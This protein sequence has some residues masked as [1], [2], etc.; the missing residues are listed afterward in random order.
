MASVKELRGLIDGLKQE[1]KEH[2]NI[3]KSA[4]E[5]T[6]SQ[7]NQLAQSASN[8]T[9]SLPTG[10]SSPSSSNSPFHLPQI[11]LPTFH[12]KPKE[13]LEHFLEKLTNL[14]QSSGVPS[15]ISLLIS[16]SN[17]YMI[18]VLMILSVKLKKSTLL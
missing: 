5:T 15:H 3:T 8:L 14:L 17:C 1:V 18:H 12:G 9:V 13:D 2:P 10:T 4:Q 11:T 6:D 16:N 7:L